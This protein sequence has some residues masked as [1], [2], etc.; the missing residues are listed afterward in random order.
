MKIISIA[1]ACTALLGAI[2]AAQ[3]VTAPFDPRSYHARVDGSPTEVYVLGTV[4]L[5]Q[6]EGF[7]PSALSDLLDRLETWAPDV[8]TIEALGGD[9]VFLMQAY[10]ARFGGAVSMFARAALEGARLAGETLGLDMPAALTAAEEMLE[11][12][13]AEPEPAARRQLAALFAASGDPHSALLQWLRLETGERVAGDGVSADLAAFLDR[14]SASNNENIQIAVALAV[15]LG[16]DRIYSADDHTA[17]YL[18][19]RMAGP[20]TEAFERPEFAAIFEHPVFSEYAM[21]PVHWESGGV[22]LAHYRAI[23]APDYGHLDAEGQWLVMVDRPWPDDVGRIRIAEWDTRNL[24]M[25]SHI[26]EASANAVGGRILSIVGAA[27]KPWL[28]A[29]LSVMTDM[30]VIDAHSVLGGSD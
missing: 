12:W 8:I 10:D 3:D 16:H 11:S 29:Y 28:D 24:R 30:R 17:S 18:M 7:D 6:Q 2:A 20:M 23:N 14:I 26:R 4:H 5:A 21:Q 9:T 27:H 13:P 25:T 22:L 15:R 1:L 19:G